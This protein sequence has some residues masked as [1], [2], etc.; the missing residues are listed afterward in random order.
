[1]GE[2]KEISLMPDIDGG[3]QRFI[4]ITTKATMIK[5]LFLSAPDQ[6]VKSVSKLCSYVMSFPKHNEGVC[7]KTRDKLKRLTDQLSR[8]T[9]ISC[10][11]PCCENMRRKYK[12]EDPT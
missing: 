12:G 1:M 10:K 9:E 4:F 5:A 8:P 7:P 6:K 11:T 3:C 2:V